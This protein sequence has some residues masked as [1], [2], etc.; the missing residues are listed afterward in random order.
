[1]SGW[2]RRWLGLRPDTSSEAREHL[3][4]LDQRDAQVQQL[5][6]DLRAAQHRNHFSELVAAAISRA[7]EGGTTS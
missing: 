4:V 7:R 1:V 2:L 3:A 5:G 6:R